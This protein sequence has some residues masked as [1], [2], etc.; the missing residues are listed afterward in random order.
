M[1]GVATSGLGGTMKSHESDLLCLAA[2]IYKDAVAKCTNVPL[3][4]RDLKTIESRFKHEGLSFLT[5]TLPDFGKD[6]DISLS[7]GRIDPTRFR[8]F[9]KRGK[10]P[11]FLQGFFDHV[12]FKDGSVRNE[13]SIEAIEGIRQIAYTFKKLLVPCTEKRVRKAIAGFVE[14]EH[15]FDAPLEPG[16]LDDFC[17]VS[18]LLWVDV[19]ARKDFCSF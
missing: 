3:D 16:A 19:F 4:L 12:F 7:R 2:C 17:Q 14:N 8:S 15:I 11:V 10:T 1:A 6:F 9:K 13:P 18:R 5:I